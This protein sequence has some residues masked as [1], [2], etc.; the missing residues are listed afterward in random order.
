[1]R[2]EL[3]EDG[4][5]RG[6]VVVVVTDSGTMTDTTLAVGTWRLRGDSLLLNYEW[7]DGTGITR[8][9]SQAG[10]ISDGEIQLSR[11][12]GIAF[13]PGIKLHFRRH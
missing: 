12:V 3:A 11:F 10:I 13:G 7:P 8:S 9:D 6:A 5:F 4:Q 1:M 2:F